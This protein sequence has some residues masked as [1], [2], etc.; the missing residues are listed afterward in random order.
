MNVAFY[1]KL[2]KIIEETRVLTDEPMKQHT[3]FRVGGNADFFVMPRTVLEIQEVLSLCAQEQMPYYI[4]GNGSNLL[5]SDKGYR[6]L[7][8]QIYK[9]MNRIEVHGTRVKAQAGALL[10]KIGAAAYEAGLTGFEF[11][12]GI[13]GAVGGA[14]VMNA[15]AYGGEMKDVLESVTV[16]TPEGKL[17]T[18]SNGELELGYRTSIVARK[19]YIV[20]EAV[21][22][23]QTGDKKEI[24]ARMDELK[25]QRTSKQPLE[26]PSAGST[27]KRPEG[28]FAGKLIQDA[29]L[30]GF[31][32]GGAQ[33]SEKHCGFVINKSGATA[34][35]IAELIRQVSEQ[36]M[37]QFGVKLEPEVKR[38]GEF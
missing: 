22:E 3:T 20:V 38:L 18:L 12:S 28:Y 15:G 31:Q 21:F 17:L 14:V 37:Q 25:L 32:I 30:R 9:E 27:F 2:I 7:I 19:G 8:L 34:A 4:L 10:S 13:P 33:V 5:V 11:A 1:N 6:G 16:I 23:L 24:R 29:G 36:V 35:D 26:Y